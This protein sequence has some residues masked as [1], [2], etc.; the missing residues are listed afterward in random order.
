[1]NAPTSLEKDIGASCLG[2]L[3]VFALLPVSWAAW[4]STVAALWRWFL[5]P[6]FPIAPHLSVPVTTGLLVTAEAIRGCI[7]ETADPGESDSVLT[8]AFILGVLY[9]A[10]LLFVGWAIK[11][12]WL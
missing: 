12:V 9:P 6:T 7:G 3:A 10:I 11:A 8:R 5:V 4:G 1:M 2:G